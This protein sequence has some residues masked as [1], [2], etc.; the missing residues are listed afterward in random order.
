MTGPRPPWR[1][2]SSRPYP[3][4]LVDELENGV[5]VS[6]PM[7]AWLNHLDALARRAVET[8]G[9]GRARHDAAMASLAAHLDTIPEL[10]E[11]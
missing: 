3:H 2:P 5:R 9:D 4:H 6:R 7:W 10:L 8:A 11:E 1:G